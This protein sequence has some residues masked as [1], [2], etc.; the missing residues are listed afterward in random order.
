MARYRG[1]LRAAVALVL[2]LPAAQRA[3]AQDTLIVDSG[4][5]RWRSGENREPAVIVDLGVIGSLAPDRRPIAARRQ[6]RKPRRYLTL[7]IPQPDAPLSPGPASQAAAPSGKPPPDAPVARPPPDARAPPALAR[8]PEPPAKPPAPA[9]SALPGRSAALSARGRPAGKTD[10]TPALR[11]F[12]DRVGGK[13]P[14]EKAA[15]PE[16]AGAAKPPD[17]APSAGRTRAQLP[18]PPRPLASRPAEPAAA[19]AASSEPGTPAR[20]RLP[21]PAPETDKPAR[22]TL[23]P[24]VA[25]RRRTARRLS[26]EGWSWE[27]PAGLQLR[28][29]RRRRFSRRRSFTKRM[30]RCSARMSVGGCAAWP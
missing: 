24:A 19:K 17:A 21:P 6:Y 5:A 15:A 16:K 23:S 9:V 1:I 27:P 10:A 8:T 7:N 26:V 18:P 4:G 13:R 3:D 28:Q 20:F 30:A 12:L 14:P 2:L 25:G 22:A 11:A 29:R